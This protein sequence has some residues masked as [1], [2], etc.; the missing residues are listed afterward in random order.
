MPTLQITVNKQVEAVTLLNDLVG[1]PMRLKGVSV[2]WGAPPPLGQDPSDPV[3]PDPANPFL[4]ITDQNNL[5]YF[6]ATNFPRI[7]GGTERFAPALTEVTIPEGEYTPTQLAQAFDEATFDAKVLPG[8]GAYNSTTV[9]LDEVNVALNVRCRWDSD[10]ARFQ[11]FQIPSA[12]LDIDGYI[13]P[14][15][16]VEG[17]EDA[18][19]RSPTNC[20]TYVLLSAYNNDIPIR[21]GLAPLT[22]PAASVGKL[23]YSMFG[24]QQPTTTQPYLVIPANDDFQPNPPTNF[25]RGGFTPD[26]FDVTEVEPAPERQVGALVDLSQMGAST[27]EF[28]AFSPNIGAHNY[29]YLPRPSYIAPNE[30]TNISQNPTCYFMP[31]NLSFNTNDIRKQFIIETKL[32]SSRGGACPFGDNALHEFTLYFDYAINANHF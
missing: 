27:R 28:N 7:P 9:N 23:C 4:V 26:G 21:A 25:L 18:T 22:I 10:E 2:S 13:T 31:L 29:L 32:D 20:P 1:Q 5:L 3:P 24:L 16:Y 17:T 12:P 30:Q 15:D 8:Y 14:P 19:R 6:Y 11:F